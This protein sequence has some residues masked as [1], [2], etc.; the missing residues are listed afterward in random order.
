MEHLKKKKNKNEG[1]APGLSLLSSQP[2]FAKLN[3][4]FMRLNVFNDRIV[5]VLY[6]RFLVRLLFFF[7]HYLKQMCLR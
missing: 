7:Y 3:I 5:L 4:Y 1:S 2:T 6:F